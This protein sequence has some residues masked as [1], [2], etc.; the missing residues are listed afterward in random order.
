MLKA[1]AD[2]GG[3]V[4][5]STSDPLCDGREARKVFCAMID[6]AFSGESRAKLAPNRIE[7]QERLEGQSQWAS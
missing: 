4:F 2:A 7:A 6:T 5:H 3:F 1:G